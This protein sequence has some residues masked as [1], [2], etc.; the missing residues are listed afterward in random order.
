VND[1]AIILLA[2]DR[3]EDIRDVNKAY[4]L[5]ANS[6]HTSGST[7]TGTALSTTGSPSCITTSI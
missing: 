1:T 3:E 6:C 7:T 5:G 2:E 4:Q